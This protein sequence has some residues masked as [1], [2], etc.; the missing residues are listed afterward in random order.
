[1]AF[2]NSF[3]IQRAAQSKFPKQK[4]IGE[5]I[6]EFQTLFIEK[7]F[8]HFDQD[9]NGFVTLEEFPKEEKDEL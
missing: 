3:Q 6:K 9:E 7:N 4:L 1:M 2:I 5:S 8:K